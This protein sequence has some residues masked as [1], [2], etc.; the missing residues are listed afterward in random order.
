MTSPPLLFD[1]ARL[2]ATMNRAAADAPTFLT[3]LAASDIA[4]RLTFVSRRF[5]LALDLGGGERLTETGQ[6]DEVMRLRPTLHGADVV[7]DEETL[8]F[9]DAS[10]DLIVSGLTLQAVNDLPG[11]L[12]QIRRAL[13]PDGLFLGL[14]PGAETLSELRTAL[15][16]AEIERRGGAALRV[17]PF[18]ETRDAGSLLQRAGFALPVTDRDRITLRYATPF[19][20]IRELRALGAGNPLKE[21][22]PMTRG[23]LARAMAIYAE[24]FSDTDGRVRATLDL[25]S[26]SGWAPHDSQQKPLRPGSAKT[27]LADALGAE[28]R[29][30]KR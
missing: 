16:E 7:G 24:R 22:E 3:D 30:L 29:V 26:L 4:D 8:P 5:P 18:L 2:R 17:A 23:L 28:E 27:R 20:L 19:H 10:L 13:K 11:A 14:V 21:R 15:A 6:V 9:R 25:V 12:V 1:R